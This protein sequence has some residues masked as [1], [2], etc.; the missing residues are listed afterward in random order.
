[1]G[2]LGRRLQRLGRRGCSA[3]VALLGARAPP[4]PPPPPLPA[5]ELW[6]HLGQLGCRAEEEHPVLG[7]PKAE[8]H[9]M[10]QLK[11]AVQALRLPSRLPA[12]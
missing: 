11:W 7:D 5:G 4:P 2:A 10:E 9:R 12:P 1:M 6:R 8:L 3:L